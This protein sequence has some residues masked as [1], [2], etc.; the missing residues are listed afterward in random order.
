MCVFFHEIFNRKNRRSLYVTV[1]IMLY[2]CLRK[3]KSYMCKSGA[4]EKR[5]ANIRKYAR[6]VCKQR[7]THYTLVSHFFL[8][9]SSATSF[10]FS[11]FIFYWNTF[12]NFFNIMH[13]LRKLYALKKVIKTILYI[14]THRL[15]VCVCVCVCVHSIGIKFVPRWNGVSSKTKYTGTAWTKTRKKWSKSVSDCCVCDCLKKDLKAR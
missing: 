11:L 3:R 1:T 14:F 10:P 5:T 12:R 13:N 6:N 9:S 2:E 4:W 15:T 7:R 8:A